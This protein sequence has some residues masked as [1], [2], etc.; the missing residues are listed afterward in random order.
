MSFNATQ[1]AHRIWTVVGFRETQ[2]CKV[3]TTKFL[4]QINIVQL[5]QLGMTT[6]VA[7]T[8]TLHIPAA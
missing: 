5:R 6:V 7:E 8:N 3:N 2:Q 4:N 1:Y